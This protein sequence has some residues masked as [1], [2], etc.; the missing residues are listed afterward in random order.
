MYGFKKNHQ[1]KEIAVGE[2]SPLVKSKSNTLINIYGTSQ[3]IVRHM[4]MCVKP[5]CDLAL[6][7]KFANTRG[8]QNHAE[9]NG[10]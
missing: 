6:G 8:T 7:R 9:K 1:L 2:M 10:K 3:G 5:A 4:Q